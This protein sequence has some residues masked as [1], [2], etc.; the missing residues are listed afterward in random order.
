MLSIKDCVD[1]CELSEKEIQAIAEHEHIPQVLAA[2][3]GENLLKSDVGTWLIKRYIADDIQY[4]EHAGEHG[5]A[6]EL[7]D[8]LEQFSRA[9]PTYDLG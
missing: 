6:S 3:L 2:E 4:A 1:Y 5:R 9:H 7:R 8:V